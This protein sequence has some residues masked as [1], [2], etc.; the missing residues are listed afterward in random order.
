M[1]V[2]SLQ[3]DTVYFNLELAESRIYDTLYVEKGFSKLDY[4]LAFDKL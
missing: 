1:E 3:E 2:L 4:I